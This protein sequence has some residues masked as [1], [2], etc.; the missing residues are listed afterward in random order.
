MSCYLE[1]VLE[2]NHVTKICNPS[3]VSTSSSFSGYLTVNI[4]PEINFI[5][6]PGLRSVAGNFI[7]CISLCQ[8]IPSPS[9]P[10]KPRHPNLKV[11]ETNQQPTGVPTHHFAP[12]FST[13]QLSQTAHYDQLCPHTLNIRRWLPEAQQAPAEGTIDLRNSS[14]CYWVFRLLF[15]Y[16]E[17]F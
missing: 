17:Y 11:I 1:V 2:A 9:F 15:H 8:S 4:T 12:S 6:D 13:P 14:W 16:A 7:T 10:S 5:N 3:T